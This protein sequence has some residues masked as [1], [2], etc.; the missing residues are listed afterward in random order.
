MSRKPIL[1]VTS[2]IGLAFL[3]VLS[4][5]MTW[6][7]A[8][9]VQS[10]PFHTDFSLVDDRGEPIDETVFHGHPALV[11]FGY[12]HCPEVC[13]TT[14]YE[15]ADW[16]KRLGPQGQPLKAYFFTVDPERDTRAVMHNYVHAFSDRITGI[17]GQPAEMAKVVDGWM[18]H[19]AKLPG[20]GSNYHMRHTASLLM[21]GADGR[22]KGLLPYGIDRDEALAKIQSAL[23]R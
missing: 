21:V 2:A 4:G 8:N 5:L 7:Y 3:T 13:P 23:L 14:L 12:T 20:G 22:L 6:L 10:G 9:E 16:L 18:I 19:A 15:V 1:V 11:Y 17:T